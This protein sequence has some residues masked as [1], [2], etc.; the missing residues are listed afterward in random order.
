MGLERWGGTEACWISAS[1]LLLWRKSAPMALKCHICACCLPRDPAKTMDINTCM[2][3]QG[4]KDAKKRMLGCIFRRI[5]NS[6]QEDGRDTLAMGILRHSRH[7]FGISGYVGDTLRR[8]LKMHQGAALG[9]RIQQMVCRM[10]AC[11]MPAVETG[12]GCCVCVSTDAA[13]QPWPMHPSTLRAV[14][15]RALEKW[16][17]GRRARKLLF[18]IDELAHAMIAP[19]HSDTALYSA[20]V[21]GGR[22]CVTPQAKPR[23]SL[24]CSRVKTWCLTVTTSNKQTPHLTTTLAGCPCY[25][26]AGSSSLFLTLFSTRGGKVVRS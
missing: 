21:T 2:Q 1:R 19:L 26:L 25:G 3:V 8:L 9:R 7:P 24:H 13:R 23:Q 6:H 12:L 17:G 4:F 11:P 20:R 18:P 14:L 16:G 22:L 15:D 10:R 5:D